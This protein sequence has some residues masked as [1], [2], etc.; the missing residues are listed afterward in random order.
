M[1]LKNK[2]TNTIHKATQKGKIKL[3]LSNN[4]HNLYITLCNKHKV[5]SNYKIIDSTAL[6][7]ITCICC[8]K[9]LGLK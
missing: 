6:N 2:I 5:R 8:L 7:K 9:K 4:Q 1:L 3:P